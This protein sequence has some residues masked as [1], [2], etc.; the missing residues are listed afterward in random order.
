M[1]KESFRSDKDVV[2]K[3]DPGFERMRG[4]GLIYASRTK[5]Y[6]GFSGVR[7][8]KRGRRQKMYN[9]L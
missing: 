1:N 5:S 6:I 7:V 9:C 3:F 2:L 8:S 4:V